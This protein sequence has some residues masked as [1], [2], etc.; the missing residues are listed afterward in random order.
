MERVNVCAISYINTV[1]FVYGLK[2]TENSLYAD[3]VLNTPSQCVSMIE[4]GKCDIAIVSVASLLWLKDVD[5]ISDYSISATNK[6]RTVELLSNS[7][8]NEITDIFLDEDSYTSSSLVRILCEELWKI[9]PNFHNIDYRKE[10]ISPSTGQGFLMIGDKVFETEDT[11]K[12]NYD[13]AAA[14]GELTSLPFV[15]AVWVARKG[16]DQKYI[17]ELNDAFHYGTTKIK[18]AVSEMVTGITTE[19][20]EEYLTNYIEFTLNRDKR[21]AID[22]FL[23]KAKLLRSKEYSSPLPSPEQNGLEK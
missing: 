8:L 10:K 2:H 23:N 12:Y 15:F 5:I 6:V 11:F 7:P 1:P 18:E 13:L 16:L 20:A 14:W 3:M 9:T 19:L 22:L 17:T 4:Q 21:K